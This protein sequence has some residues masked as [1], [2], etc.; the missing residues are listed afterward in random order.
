[1]GEAPTTT[2]FYLQISI[3]LLTYALYVATHLIFSHDAPCAFAL[4]GE[5][6]T[7]WPKQS[8]EVR[9]AGLKELQARTSV[10][11][12]VAVSFVD[13]KKDGV[14]YEMGVWHRPAATGIG[15]FRLLR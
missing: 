4:T 10:G 13:L 9:L 8:A 7:V 12:Q 5:P 2:S 11:T 14:K 1:M 3:L 6:K 15:E